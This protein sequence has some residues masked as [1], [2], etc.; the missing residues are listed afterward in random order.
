MYIIQSTIKLTPTVKKAIAPAGHR[1]IKIPNVMAAEFSLTILPQSAIGGFMPSPK[2][3]NDAIKRN[4]KQNRNPNSAI[5][6]GMAFG[7]ISCRMS[8]QRPSPRNLAAST[9]SMT[10]MSIAT[11]R[12]RR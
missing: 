4:T 10:T 1:G 9:K 11:A 3:L 12:D 6:G 5:R 8:H 2:K 7:K